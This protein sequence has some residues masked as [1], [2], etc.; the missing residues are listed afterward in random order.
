MTETDSGV[1]DQVT[2]AKE[3]LLAEGF[4]EVK[5]PVDL[6]KFAGKVVACADPSN[7]DFRQI[8]GFFAKNT[9]GKL[10]TSPEQPWDGMTFFSL[11]SNYGPI[12]VRELSAEEAAAKGWTLEQ[13]AIAFEKKHLGDRLRRLFERFFKT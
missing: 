11:G 13:V 10:H 3:A 9:T 6:Q 5:S 2:Q 4:A 12:F 8:C 1:A 7:P